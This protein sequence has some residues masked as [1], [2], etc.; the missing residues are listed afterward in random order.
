MLA[1]EGF[2]ALGLGQDQLNPFVHLVLYAY[3]YTSLCSY[4]VVHRA[5]I[6]LVLGFGCAWSTNPYSTHIRSA[7][8]K[9]RVVEKVPLC[10]SFGQHPSMSKEQVINGATA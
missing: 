7:C 8:P 9:A 3:Q 1:A 10:N 4:Y 5:L 6:D 2:R